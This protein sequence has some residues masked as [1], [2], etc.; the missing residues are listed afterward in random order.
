MDR[1]SA[2]IV[3]L[4]ATLVVVAC[5]GAGNKPSGASRSRVDAVQA[6]APVEVDLT[7]FCERLY[8]PQSAPALSLPPLHAPAADAPGAGGKR[9]INVWA[10][11]CKPCIEELPRLARWRTEIGA[12]ADFELVFLSADGDPEAVR[13]FAQTHPEVSGTLQLESAAQ[14]DPWVTSLGLPG[15]AILPVHVFV[16]AGDRVRCL[17][18]AGIGEGDRAAVEQLLVSM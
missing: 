12:R 7:G 8:E 1:L 4:L 6:A 10:T 17:R 16:D 11:W 5:D 15:S 14:L 18:T 2:L 3:P 9:W 13:A